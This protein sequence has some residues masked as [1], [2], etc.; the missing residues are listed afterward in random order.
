MNINEQLL[1]QK[2]FWPSNKEQLAGN[3]VYNYTSEDFT[4]TY[5]ISVSR[6]NEKFEIF[7]GVSPTFS[8]KEMNYFVQMFFD[9]KEGQFELDKKKTS[10]ELMK[11]EDILNTLDS[12]QNNIM[13]MSAKPEFFST[14]ILS[15]A[16]H[17][18]T[19]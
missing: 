14:G 18:Y 5:E 6:T 11:D 8:P 19:I 17:K 10:P 3:L 7:F 12:I 13:K 9:R 16:E 2:V 1:L 15:R 4:E